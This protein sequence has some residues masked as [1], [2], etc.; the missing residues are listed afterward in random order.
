MVKH[1][2]NYYTDK[3]YKELLSHMVILCDTKEKSNVNIIKYFDENGIAYKKRS[4]KTG[5]YSI[6]VEACPELGF[7][8]DTYFTDE[9]VIERKNGLKELASNLSNNQDDDRFMK[10]LNRMI[11]VSNVYLVVE[12]DRLDDIMEH[13]YDSKYNE[14][15]FLRT[16]LTWQ[17]RS[18]F[19]LNFVNRDNMGKF[20]YEIC[21]N[22]LDNSILK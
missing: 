18:N 12:N 20:I 22:C 13:N 1:I 15:S 14:D 16:L 3:K 10:E 9:L 11:N 7:L 21:K 8:V 17:K 6:M 5:D 4:L 2:K 19:Y